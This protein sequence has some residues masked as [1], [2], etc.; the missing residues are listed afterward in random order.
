MEK[1]TK[2]IVLVTVLLA[3][4]GVGAY[5]MFRKKPT[6]TD[7]EDDNTPDVGVDPNLSE[8]QAWKLGYLSNRDT[9]KH[10]VHLVNRPSKDTIVSGDTVRISGTSGE[11]DGDFTVSSV[12][13]DASNN[14]GAVYL[15]IPYTP[16]GNTD[17]SFENKGMLELIK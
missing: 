4:L 16:N 9:G 14:V 13:I 17:R 11:F 3:G 10:A 5:F 7:T 8:Y 12:W 15:P 1:K 2:I 6:D